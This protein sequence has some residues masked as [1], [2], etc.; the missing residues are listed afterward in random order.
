M[1]DSF[2]YDSYDSLAIYLYIGLVR[3]R[4]LSMLIA[5]AILVTRHYHIVSLY[6]QGG[7]TGVSRTK[8]CGIP[9]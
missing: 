7:F 9:R 2:P 1:N 8:D 3:I 4:S 6:S 5:L